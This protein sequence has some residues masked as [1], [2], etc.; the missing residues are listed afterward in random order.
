MTP[1]VFASYRL[2]PNEDLRLNAFAKKIFRVATFNEM[3]YVEM[4]SSNI[5]P[6]YAT[7]YD[8]GLK[9]T[10]RPRYSI[11][12]NIDAQ[13]DVYYNLV[14]DKI[15]CTP[16]SPLFKWTTYN[17]GLVKIK[18]LDVS[19]G[20]MFRMGNVFLQTK[21]QYTYQEARNYTDPGDTFYGHQIPYIP[22]HSGTVIASALYKDW[23]LNYSFIYTG[24]RY[25]QSDNIVYNHVQP[26]YTHDV[27]LVKKFKIKDMN[28]KATLE[29]N[30]LFDQDYEV[31][32]NY[33][34]PKRNYRFSLVVEL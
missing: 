21:L 19:V 1:A 28:F 17:L 9:Y 3:Y 25:S 20:N 14:E 8:L 31:I 22:W 13:I 23:T 10:K 16:K 33:P 2:L 6:E 29:V 18:G 5:K 4:I 7:Q 27:S 32:F 34:M 11:V 24:E 15:I 12:K 30:N 26:W